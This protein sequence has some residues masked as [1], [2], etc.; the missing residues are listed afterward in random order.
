MSTR[1]ALLIGLLLVF[2]SPLNS[3]AY[4]FFIDDFSIIKN[5]N[6]WFSDRFDDGMP[7]P[8]APNFEG[9]STAQYLVKG[10]VGPESGGK[11][12][13]ISS[14]AIPTIN[15]A[16][17]HNL[18]QGA[19][20]Q[21]STDN[22]DLTTGLKIDDSFSVEGVFDL[23]L[24]E[25]SN[26]SYGIRLQDGGGGQ[27]A[28]QFVQIKVNRSE[29]NVWRILYEAQDLIKGTQTT[30][31]KDLIEEGHEQIVLILAKESATSNAITA[32]Y[33]YKDGGVVGAITPFPATAE[34]F[35]GENYVRAQFNAS[36]KIKFPWSMFLPAIIQGAN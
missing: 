21:T 26:E 22:Q 16:G 17:E 6:L 5:G 11:L 2:F 34:M 24:P 30:I 12:A 18:F 33:A 10:A 25:R 23:V 35:D 3:Y 19:T 29:N 8:S 13:L 14:D 4:T 36:R 7:P 32:F 1:K 28:D 27:D 15:V 20:L 31:G 9:G